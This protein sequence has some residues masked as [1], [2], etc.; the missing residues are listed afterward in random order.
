MILGKYPFLVILSAFFCRSWCFSNEIKESWYRHS[1][2]VDNFK[3]QIPQARSFEIPELFEQDDPLVL[4]VENV[5]PS[6]TILHRCE[7]AGCCSG[8]K[9]CAPNTTEIVNLIFGI[10]QPG[11]SKIDYVNK[12]VVNH[13]SCSCEM[14]R[15]D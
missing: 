13:T 1:Q 8:M 10:V 3:C 11:V 15:I 5:Y 9:H 4:H 2:S 12:D 14:K 7:N 6:T